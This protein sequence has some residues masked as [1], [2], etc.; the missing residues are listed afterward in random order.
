VENFRSISAS[1]PRSHHHLERGRPGLTAS[2][3]DEAAADAEWSGAV[4]KGA[5]I[6]LVVSKST[7][8]SDGVDLS[9][10][11]IVDKNLAPVLS[12]SYGTCETEMT[13]GEKQLYPACGSRPRRKAL[14]LWSPQAT[15][16]RHSA[17]RTS[18]YRSRLASERHGFHSL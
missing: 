2:D 18:H 9:A 5:T 1:R 8:A 12:S 17:T 4:A 10:E 11:Y 13:A 14:P 7:T 6:N 16:V 3:E 15:A